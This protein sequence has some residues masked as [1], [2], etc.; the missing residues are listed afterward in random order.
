M[1]EAFGDIVRMLVWALVLLA[2]LALCNHLS[3]QPVAVIT[4]PESVPPGE[5]TVISSKGSEGDNLQWIK[6][7]GLTVVQVGCEVMDSQLIFATSRPGRYEF[8]LVVADS[9]ARI[10]YAKHVVAVG[11]PPPDPPEEPTPAPDPEPEPPTQPGKWGPLEKV[12]RSN[13]DRLND[14]TTRAALKAA[15]TSKIADLKNLCQLGQCPSL[16]EAKRQIT[17]TIELVLLQRQNRSAEWAL[18]WRTPNAQSLD[19]I[20]VVNL[21]DYLNA[22]GAI[23]AGL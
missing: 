8:I 3:A 13:A 21:E 7:D 5:L 19:S 2:T 1:K 12:S 18:V 23:A 9:E 4:A 10:T 6:P 16:S 20:G 15:I 17:G 22:A 11:Q 14:P